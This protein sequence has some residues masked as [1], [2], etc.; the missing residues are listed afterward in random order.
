M[1]EVVLHGG[2]KKLLPNGRIK[3]E[4]FSPVDCV[5]LLMG[6][7]PGFQKLYMAR[8]YFLSLDGDTALNDTAQQM[9]FGKSTHMHIFPDVSGAKA[10]GGAPSVSPE[11]SAYEDR[12]DDTL[13]S[14]FNGGL[15]TS[16]QGVCIPVI[17]GRV[18]RAGSAVVSAG[19]GVE[20]ATLEQEDVFDDIVSI[21][22]TI[23]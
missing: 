10:G 13:S 16:E 2:L 19:I 18:T 4:A 1:I 12:E 17:Y 22:G 6:V 8:P 7:V 20:R 5:R 9:T 21:M 3:L 23:P 14:L 15:N 11:S